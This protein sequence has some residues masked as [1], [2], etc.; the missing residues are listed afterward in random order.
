M[1]LRAVHRTGG[2]FRRLRAID[3][4]LREAAVNAASE[5]LRDELARE[6]GKEIVVVMQTPL[7]A[8]GSLDPQDAERE[9][10]TLDQ[11]PS[12]WLAPVLR[13]ALEPM[14]AAANNAVARAVSAKHKRKK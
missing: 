13:T 9:F 3:T 2:L 4:R 10:G 7:R 6:S 14:R 12:P 8:V 5:T 1:R 11:P